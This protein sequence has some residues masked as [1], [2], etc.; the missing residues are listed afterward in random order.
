[1]RS[2]AIRMGDGPERFQQSARCGARVP[3]SATSSNGCALLPASDAAG[4]HPKSGT[5]PLVT[6]GPSHQERRCRT[7][8]VEVF[9]CLS[10]WLAHW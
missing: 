4:R 3:A 5:E 10:I 1:M 7:L 9:S 6:F 8:R 2:S